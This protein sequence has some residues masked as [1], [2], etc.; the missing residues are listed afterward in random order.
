MNLTNVTKAS[1]PEKHLSFSVKQ[2][3]A[4][5]AFLSF[6]QLLPILAPA[7]FSPPLSFVGNFLEL[8][9]NVY[10]ILNGCSLL[11]RSVC[12]R[13]NFLNL[14]NYNMKFSCNAFF[15]FPFSVFCFLFWYSLCFMLYLLDA[16]RKTKLTADFH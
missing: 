3:N 7:F 15:C 4:F 16:M 12:R 10:L 6:S 5:C 11:F 13:L 1:N 8:P 14:P 9:R 2:Y